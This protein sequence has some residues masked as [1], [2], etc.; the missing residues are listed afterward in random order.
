MSVI[1]PARL[2]LS[3]VEQLVAGKTDWIKAK[4][5]SQSGVA[6]PAPMRFVSG[7]PLLYLGRRY[8]LDVQA[9]SR[10][11]TRLDGDVVSVWVPRS[12]RDHGQYVRRMLER[13][14]RQRA[15]EDIVERSVHFAGVLDV[16]PASLSVR[17]YSAR[18]GSCNDRGELRFNWKI[19]MAPPA[20]VDY[21]VVHELSHLR[22]LDHSVAFWRC[23]ESACP[24]YRS[25]RGWLRRNAGS[26]TH[27]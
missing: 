26:L 8:A 2:P 6:P 12:V 19:I 11:G 7:A 5:S 15:L 1:V 27:F 22:H 18:W 3:A 24:D 10:G 23:V 20:V 25:A 4:L 17:T 14:Y 21:V 16:A 9:G 13:W